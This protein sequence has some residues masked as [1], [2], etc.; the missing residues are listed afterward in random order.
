MRETHFDL[1]SSPDV[2]VFRH[3]GIGEHPYADYIIVFN[4][5]EFQ[6]MSQEYAWL[7]NICHQ[8]C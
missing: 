6:Q 3:S 4:R 7:N 2:H 8:S 1:T 5:D